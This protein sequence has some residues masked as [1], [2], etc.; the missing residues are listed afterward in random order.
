MAEEAVSSPTISKDAENSYE[1]GQITS[2]DLSE[3]ELISLGGNRD[4]DKPEAESTVHLLKTPMIHPEFAFEDA[5]IEVQVADQVFWVHEFQ[6]NKLVK[7]RK[8]IQ[9]ARETGSVS[10]SGNRVKVVCDG[11]SSDFCNTFRVLYSPAI[12]GV[13]EF[14]VDTLISALRI[15]SAYDY[16]D[17]RNFAIDELEKCSLPAIDQIGLSDEFFLPHWEKPA[18]VDLCHRAEPI[19]S[20]EAQILGIE[21]FAEIARIREAQQHHR[22][23]ELFNK[24]VQPYHLLTQMEGPD[25]MSALRRDAEFS[26]RHAILPE[27]NCRV[28]KDE[29]GARVLVPCQIHKLAPVILKESRTLF[30]QR[31][32]LLNR[33]ASLN[34]AVTAE[35]LAVADEMKIASV[36]SEINRVPW[37]RRESSKNGTV[38]PPSS[39]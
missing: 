29:S 20:S 6:L 32:E 18:F 17:L 23:M 1:P 24:S 39:F 25:K 4:D 3:I 36:E 19:T 5:N 28:R 27:C 13:P 33:L 16:A 12:L 9:E 14:E 31:N 34:K 22:L 37:V 2:P 30:E 7:I 21:R 8:L 38:L 10:D 15:T 11:D 35:K 26:S